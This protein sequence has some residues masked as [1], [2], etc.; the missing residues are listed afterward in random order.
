MVTQ[1]AGGAVAAGY[2]EMPSANLFNVTG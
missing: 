2:R 1:Q